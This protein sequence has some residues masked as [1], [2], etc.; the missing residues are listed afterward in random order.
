MDPNER[1]CLD[2][3]DRLVD[4]I[5]VLMQLYIDALPAVFPD[6]EWSAYLTEVLDEYRRLKNMR[7]VVFALEAVNVV[8]FRKVEEHAVRCRREIVRFERECRADA[9]SELS[10]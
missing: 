1:R 5:R 2:E 9:I 7:P 4:E 6:R 10:T 8:V 3:R